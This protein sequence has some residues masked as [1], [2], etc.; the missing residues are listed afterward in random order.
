VILERSDREESSDSERG[1]SVID[2]A[3]DARNV[4][5]QSERAGGAKTRKEILAV[6][7][8][9]GGAVKGTTSEEG[10]KLAGPWTREARRGLHGKGK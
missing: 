1:K 9:Q 5:G 7:E 3:S 4:A 10:E 2:F 6:I 8:V